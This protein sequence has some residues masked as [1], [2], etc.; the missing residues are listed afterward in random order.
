MILQR[1]FQHA[2]SHTFTKNKLKCVCFLFCYIPSLLKNGLHFKWLRS[3]VFVTNY[4]ITPSYKLSMILLERCLVSK[5]C[6]HCQ[7][8]MRLGLHGRFLSWTGLALQLD[9]WKVS[10]LLPSLVN[11]WPL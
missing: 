11:S 8:V 5:H 1:Y 4:L 6:K 3:F 2:A 10:V 9:F 7:P